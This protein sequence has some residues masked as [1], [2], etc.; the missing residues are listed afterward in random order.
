M[1]EVTA[2]PDAP[3]VIRLFAPHLGGPYDPILTPG[4]PLASRDEWEDIVAAAK[5]CGAQSLHVAFHGYG[6]EHDRQLH[7]TG[8]FDE[9]CLAV[10]RAQDQGLGTGANVFLTKPGLRQSTACSTS[11]SSGWAGWRSRR[12]RTPRRRARALAEGPVSEAALYFSDDGPA[13]AE[14]AARYGDRAGTLV[15]FEAPSV[16]FRW[17]DQAVDR[18]SSAA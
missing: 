8:A 4:T 12:R 10:R 13:A 11:S 15:Y 6:E 2:H 14:L 1:H 5:E 17:R 3:D 18:R 7:R 16:R 9:T